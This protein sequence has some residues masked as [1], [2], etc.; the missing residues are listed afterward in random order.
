MKNRATASISAISPSLSRGGSLRN[1]FI[2]GYACN[3]W[4]IAFTS[5]F[6]IGRTRIETSRINSTECST[7][8]NRDNL[9]EGRI[10]PAPDQDLE[11]PF[12]LAFDNNTG[13]VC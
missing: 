11:S 12:L 5:A 3:S 1:P 2:R 8:T 9:P 4:I 6:P 13:D 10:N 7:H